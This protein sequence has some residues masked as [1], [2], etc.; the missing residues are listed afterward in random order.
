[1]SRAKTFNI[2]RDIFNF[3]QLAPSVLGLLPG[4]WFQQTPGRKRLTADVTN[5]T[6]TF[7]A[8]TEL[9]VDLIAGHK[10]TGLMQLYTTDTTAADGMKIDFGASTATFNSIQ[11]AFVASVG[12]TI[13]TAWSAAA[14]TPILI[15]A[16]SATTTRP[17]TFSISV[18]CALPGT[19]A[20]R[21][22]KN[23]DGAGGTLTIKKGGWLWLENMPA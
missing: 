5:I 4:K 18:D 6:T 3:N 23:S 16:F 2:M 11:F 13:S 14:E 22:A 19:L 15:T 12:S 9:S 7:A 1:M 21:Q 17:T 8:M 10:Y 20:V